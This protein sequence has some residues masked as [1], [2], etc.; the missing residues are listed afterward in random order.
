MATPTVEQIRAAGTKLLELQDADF[1]RRQ[2]AEAGDALVALFVV[3]ATKLAPKDADEQRARRVEMM[4]AAYFLRGDLDGKKIAAPD[5]KKARMA[6]DGVAGL[7][8]AAL[9]KRISLEVGD[10]AMAFFSAFV[11]KVTGAAEAE[12]VQL[13]VLAFLLRKDLGA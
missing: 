5:E 8:G 4:V 7:N 10:A 6:V 12:S 13:M 11:N 3:L 9:D 2:R 1:K